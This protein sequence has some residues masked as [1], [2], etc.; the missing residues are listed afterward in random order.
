MSIAK[1]FTVTKLNDQPLEIVKKLC[2]LGDTIGATTGATDSI[3][4]IRN[5]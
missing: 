1:D 3:T 5:G 2:Y 4:N